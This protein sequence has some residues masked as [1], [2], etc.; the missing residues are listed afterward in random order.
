MRPD[1]PGVWANDLIP[2]FAI[3][4]NC[5]LGNSRYSLEGPERRWNPY[6]GAPTTTLQAPPSRLLRHAWW[7][8]SIITQ[9]QYTYYYMYTLLLA[10]P[11][12]RSR[13]YF[14]PFRG[15]RLLYIL[16]LLQHNLPLRIVK[17]MRFDKCLSDNITINIHGIFPVICRTLI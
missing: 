5:R 15:S 11:P 3:I 9:I 4:G 6:P 7:W 12:S 14:C 10:I 2:N 17:H 16:A 13:A 8:V 1:A